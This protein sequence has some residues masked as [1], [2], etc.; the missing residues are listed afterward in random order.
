VKSKPA[1]APP[2]P[3]FSLG[4]RRYL[5]L[6]AAVMGGVIMLIE[7]LG[8]KMLSPYVGTS[9]FVWV[10][11]IGVA[12]LALACGYYVG[13]RV[14]DRSPRL[15]GLYKAHLVAAAWLCVSVLICEPVAF[16]CLQFKLA[17]G[18]VLASLILYF[19]PLTLLAMTCPFLLRCVAESLASV[20][21]QMGRLTSVSTF[22]SFAGTVLIGYVLIPLLPNSTTMLLAAGVVVAVA[23]GYFLG[24]ARRSSPAAALVLAWGFVAFGAFASG[25]LRSAQLAGAT[26]LFRGNSHFGMLQVVEQHGTRYYLNDFLTQN[27]YDPERRQSTSMFTYMLTELARSYTARLDAALCIGMG[28][29]IAPMDL[30]HSGV[31]V[32]VVEINPG[33]VPVAER[34]FDFDSSRVRLTIGDGREV[35]NRFPNRYDAILLDAFL[36]D[37]SPSHL[38]TREAFATMQR[39]LTPGGVLVINSFGEMDPGNDFFTA[40]LDLTLKAV[41]KQV[42]IHASGNGNVFFVAGDGELALLRQPDIEPMHPAVRSGVRLAFDRTLTPTPGRGMVLTDDFNPVEYYDAANREELRKNLAFAMRRR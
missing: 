14:A 6:T 17:L 27:T 21:G 30:A 9:H 37:S 40:S 35:L 32:D 31:K 1:A 23:S 4:L 7:I 25:R 18:T 28:V 34:F 11:Q 33:V 42:R 15:G 3:R 10:A 22:G 20:G 39:R 5:Y 16:W 13:G 24:W 19:V 12:M 36:G 26:E 2:A 38:M 41:F 29:G 8:A